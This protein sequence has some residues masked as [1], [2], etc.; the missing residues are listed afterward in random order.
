MS[1]LAVWVRAPEPAG[2]LVDLRLGL[3][4]SPGGEVV[5]WS[6]DHEGV[7]VG[8][9]GWAPVVLGRQAPLPARLF[10]D[11]PRWLS[12][13]S[14]GS[15]GPSPELAPRQPLDGRA[16][17]LSERLAELAA[18]QSAPPEGLGAVRDAVEGLRDHLDTV[19]LRMDQ[20]TV[21]GSTRSARLT[22]AEARVE[23]AHALIEERADALAD[24]AG[25]G[26]ELH[27]HERRIQR[28][29]AGLP[30]GSA[31][32]ASLVSVHKPGETPRRPAPGLS[33]SPAVEVRMS[34]ELPP[35]PWFDR[36]REAYLDGSA[37]VFVLHGLVHDLH[38]A[39]GQDG[40][41]WGPLADAV[42][43]RLAPSR[44][45]VLRLD[46]FHG[47]RA[48]NARARRHLEGRP[49]EPGLRP[50][51]ARIGRLLGD[52]RQSTAV[53]IDHADLLFPAARPELPDDR[54]SRSALR[55]WLDDPGLRE[56]NNI[57]FLIAPQR[58]SLAT[59]LREHPRVLSVEVEP[60]TGPTVRAYLRSVLGVDVPLADA[61]QLDG[62][63]LSR[64][65]AMSRL[66]R[67]SAPVSPDRW[68][69]L[70]APSFLGERSLDDHRSDPADTAPPDVG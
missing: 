26:G 53:V 38:P 47:L 29:E 31:A 20:L 59:E 14:L 16:L 52:R 55:H 23:A 25:P 46:P 36:V 33:P 45:L 39:E 44:D 50:A 56:S 28:L 15:A 67:S 12:V 18:R 37:S 40:L 19:V 3:H 6:E 22:A 9:G 60:H 66:A 70:L 64:V 2:G 1:W 7:P 41:Q 21:A 17:A 10:D 68:M 34:A 24:V 63:L 43:A 27:D 54:L 51:L 57:L 49:V 48:D 5:L 32:V 61:L 13:R 62:L 30:S 4:A 11:R 58:L 35:S 42:S 65:G 8:Q 69:E